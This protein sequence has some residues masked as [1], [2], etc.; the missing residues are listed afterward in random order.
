MFHIA[1]GPPELRALGEATVQAHVTAASAKL[2][3]RDQVQAVVFVYEAG[4]VSLGRR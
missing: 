4:V 1:G 2:G 3:L